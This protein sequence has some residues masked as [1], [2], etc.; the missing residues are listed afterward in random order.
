MPITLDKQLAAIDVLRQENIFVIDSQRARTQ[1][2][3]PLKI[4]V[5][6]LMPKKANTPLQLEVEFLY[7]ASHKSKNTSNEYLENYYR[8]FA[9]IM[10]TPAS[11]F[12]GGRK[13]GFT[14]TLGSTSSLWKRSC[15]AFMSRK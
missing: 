5:V 15:P 14:I 9:D 4:L 1:N 11:T 10:S 13:P 7:M 8:T 2:I 12:A 3:R 6:N